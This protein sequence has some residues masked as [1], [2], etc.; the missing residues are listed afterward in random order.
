MQKMGGVAA[1]AGAAINLLGLVVF[2]AVLAP[3]GFGSDDADPGRIVTLLADNQAWMRVWYEAQFFAFGASLIIL[4]VA[5]FERLKA[6]SPVLAH[7]VT[8]LGLIWAVLVI[9][10]GALTISDLTTVARLHA[11]DPAQAASVW[12]SLKS[13]EDGLGGGGGETVV[14]SVWFLLL[15]AAAAHTR[16]LPRALAYLGM[17]IGAAGILSVVLASIGLMA[18]YGLGLI[19][20]LA[21]LGVVMLRNSRGSEASLVSSRLLTTRVA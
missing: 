3:K 19:M 6:G 7:A 17:A 4:S 11:E 21:W 14:N 2:A 20:R 18:V 9:A 8:G 15:G 13:V 12:L 10:V 5:L 16:E 1:L